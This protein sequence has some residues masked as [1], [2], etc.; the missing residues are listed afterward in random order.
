M[1]GRFPLH[2]FLV[3]L[4]Y[5]KDVYE[6]EKIKSKEC[7]GSYQ[8]ERRVGRGKEEIFDFQLTGNLFWKRKS[9]HGS[10]FVY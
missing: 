9:N 2:T 4:T 5:T 8:F 6:Q 10:L 7:N 3:Y 1:M